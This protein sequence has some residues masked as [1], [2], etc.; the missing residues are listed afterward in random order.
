[1]C[2]VAIFAVI[3]YNLRRSY[4][5]GRK[6]GMAER[7][8]Y[9][10]L[11]VGRSAGE[12]EIRTAYRRLARKY[13]PDLNPGN[14]EAERQFKE[15]GEAYEVLS[16][17]EKRKAYDQFGAAGVRMGAG[18]G[19]G[20]GAG[21]PGGARYTWTTEGSP[22]DDV[23]FEAF[24][25]ST[26]QAEGLFEEI[27]SR[28]GMGGARGGARTGPRPRAGG[29]RGRDVETEIT[30][31]FEQAVRGVETGISAQYP[32]GDGMP[33]PE[34][35]T[36]KI[37]PGVREGQR[38]RLRGKGGP[39]LG[40][41]PPG[42]LYLV[43]HVAAHPYFRREGHDI[44]I[45]VPISVSEAALGAVI[46]V[47]TVRGRTSVHVPPGTASGARLRLRGQGLP[48]P[49]TAARGDQYCVIR[50]VPPRDLDE[51]RRRLFEEL[52]AGGDDN[53]REGLPWSKP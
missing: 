5:A 3:P 9:E 6:T 7:D 16:D 14:K 18:A 12:D 30:L 49:K 52:R 48:D 15:I 35:L 11:G 36:V 32:T 23:A 29:V 42:D 1:M 34:T 43:I 46:D 33:R 20:P 22:F 26:G 8:Y 28:L 41:G 40:G 53:P 39:G 37:P 10:V 27:F 17:P 31:S 25:G 50:I 2:C 51:R 38:L 24:G 44:Y 4:L 45:D 21:G 19:A 13:H 47:P